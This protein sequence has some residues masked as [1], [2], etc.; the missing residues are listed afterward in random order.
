MGLRLV[1]FLGVAV[2]LA[3]TMLVRLACR[4]GR[5]APAAVEPEPE[6]RERRIGPHRRTPPRRSPTMT[7]GDGA[8]TAEDPPAAQAGDWSRDPAAA[9]RR[10]A[11]RARAG[12]PGPAP[13]TGSAPG[14]AAAPGD[15]ADDLPPTIWPVTRDG[16]QGALR[17]RIDEI[18]ECYEGWLAVEPDLAG[19]VTVGFRIEATDGPRARITD[20]DISVS[21]LHHPWLEGCIL[22]MIGSLTFENPESGPATVR[23]PFRFAPG[24]SPE[25]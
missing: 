11:S 25:R 1:L 24:P 22:A 4:P 17:E 7:V 2:L 21:D 9:A 19:A 10:A 13:R 14:G 5:K 16:I 8:A 23:Y 18:K 20:V 15:D 12:D 6:Q 3:G